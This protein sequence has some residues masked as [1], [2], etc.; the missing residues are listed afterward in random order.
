MKVATL[1]FFVLVAAAGCA[2]HR[3]MSAEDWKAANESCK[4]HGGAM[5]MLR[6]DPEETEF[7]AVCDD[8]RQV[9]V[10]ML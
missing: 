2:E 7:T 8:G 5:N 4:E 3:H 6:A 1:F 9:V 10:A